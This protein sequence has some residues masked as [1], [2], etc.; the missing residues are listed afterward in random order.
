[1]RPRSLWKEKNGKNHKL[2][3][4]RRPL[5][6]IQR[7]LLLWN[8]HT[9]DFPSFQPIFKLST[10]MLIFRNKPG[11]KENSF[12]PSPSLKYLDF[13]DVS[14]NSEHIKTFREAWLK[15]QFPKWKSLQTFSIT[16]N[17]SFYPTVT[18]RKIIW[19]KL[20]QIF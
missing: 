8:F 16:V 3:S 13:Y 5:K 18:G 2:P 17:K 6:K 12:L 10:R 9:E 7:Y 4:F 14:K 15:S 20:I 11:S 19:S 1:M